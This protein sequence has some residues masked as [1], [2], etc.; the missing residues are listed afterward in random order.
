MTCDHC[1]KASQLKWYGGINANCE[2]CVVRQLAK[3][4]RHIREDVYEAM[5]EREGTEAV[6][7]LKRR[8][9][10]EYERMKRMGEV[11]PDHCLSTNQESQ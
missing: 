9:A 6:R 2:G 4:P 8:V 7:E 1:I 3:S 5:F 10:A 11:K